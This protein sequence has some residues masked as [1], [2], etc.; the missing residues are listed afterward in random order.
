[1][2]GGGQT[3]LEV[4]TVRSQSEVRRTAH[5]GC[6]KMRQQRSEQDKGRVKWNGPSDS[7]KGS[8]IEV[9]VQSVQCAWAART[10]D[11]SAE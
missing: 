11:E 2:D 10:N 1:M 5:A 9:V 3:E 4:A 8:G 6:Q 7:E